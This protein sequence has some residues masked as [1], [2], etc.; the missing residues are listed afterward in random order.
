MRHPLG[1]R[2]RSHRASARP[3]ASKN[4]FAAAKRILEFSGN[5]F[6]FAFSLELAVA[7]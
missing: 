5:R 1:A 2:S 3:F 6:G 7:G 4:V